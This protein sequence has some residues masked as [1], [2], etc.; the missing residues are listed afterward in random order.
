MTWKNVSGISKFQIWTEA[1]ASS[2]DGS[3]AWLFVN[4]RH[5]IKV[6][7]GLTLALK[8]GTTE[9]PS[10][11]EVKNA[12][13]LIN[14]KDGGNFKY[15]VEGSA[16]TY[17]KIYEPSHSSLQANLK[18]NNFHYVFEHYF[19]SNT[20]KNPNI[21]SEE[22]SVKLTYTDSDGK[23]WVND[24]SANGDFYQKGFVKVHCL[25]AKNNKHKLVKNTSQPYYNIFDFSSWN[26][27]DPYVDVYRMTIEDTYFLIQDFSLSPQSWRKK[28]KGITCLGLDM[29]QSD[30]PKWQNTT[31]C[32]CPT[33]DH[34][35]GEKW[36]SVD[37][38]VY[39]WPDQNDGSYYGNFRIEGYTQKAHEIVFFCTTIDYDQRNS[40]HCVQ[41]PTARFITHDQF[42]NE[43]TVDVAI[44]W[45]EGCY[46]MVWPTLDGRIPPCG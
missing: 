12:L 27:E 7:V 23:L 20:S 14:N 25:S 45:G 36:Y 6:T 38:Y 21:A 19:S 15:L 1:C 44:K 26:H 17:C 31:Q 16:G 8:I 42:G 43:S 41:R 37:A 39:K 29:Y 32:F 46:N 28:Q 18:E 34:G 30:G 4:G 2:T 3:E 33:L 24:M 9:L 10:V 40:N 35:L 22:I 5:Q 13:T 11:D